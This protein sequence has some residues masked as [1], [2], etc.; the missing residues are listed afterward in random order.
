MKFIDLI[1]AAFIAIA[2]GTADAQT[3]V[4]TVSD[5]T[6]IDGIVVNGK[7]Y[8]VTF[9]SGTFQD[10]S[11]GGLMFNGYVVGHDA[12]AALLEA[13]QRF[14]PLGI[15][16]QRCAYGCS[17]LVPYSIDA[18]KDTWSAQLQTDGYF[19][20]YVPQY[21]YLDEFPF[22][23]CGCAYLSG[24]SSDFWWGV[25]TPVSAPEP[26]TY[27]LMF[28]GLAGAALARRRRALIATSPRI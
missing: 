23:W 26:A 13:M 12:S 10:V 25:F 16:Q 28:F 11:P 5:A 15:D 18:A 19:L 2:C 17:V 20:P 22:G 21:W 24:P 3:L 7:A 1:A 6:G 27:G 4:G 9:E 8:N 14:N